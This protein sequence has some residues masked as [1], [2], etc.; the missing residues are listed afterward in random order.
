MAKTMTSKPGKPSLAHP[1]K[2]L[3]AYLHPPKKAKDTVSH[4]YDT[5]NPKGSY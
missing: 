2:N 3:G 4:A 1:H 5:R